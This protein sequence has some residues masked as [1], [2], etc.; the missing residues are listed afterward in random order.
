MIWGDV[1]LPE[2]LL[3]GNLLQLSTGYMYQLLTQHGADVQWSPICLL[4][5]QEGRRWLGG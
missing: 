4:N 2:R 3:C 1:T 5:A